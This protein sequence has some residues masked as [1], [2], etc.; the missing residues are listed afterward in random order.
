MK[1]LTINTQPAKTGNYPSEVNELLSDSPSVSFV[2]LNSSE[3][4]RSLRP[5]LLSITLLNHIPPANLLHAAQQQLPLLLRLIP[6]VDEFWR[7]ASSEKIGL[8]ALQEKT[9]SSLRQNAPCIDRT[10]MSSVILVVPE[11]RLLRR[12][13]FLLARGW[14]FEN[15]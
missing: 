9:R 5:R 15:D 4:Q 7:S 6:G 3:G 14:R 8:I 1:V 10:K 2:F 13:D 12:C 11:K